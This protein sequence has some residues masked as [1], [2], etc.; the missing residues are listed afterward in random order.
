MFEYKPRH[1]NVD[2]TGS[3]SSTVKRSAT[4]VNVTG[5]G[6]NHYKRKPRVTISMAR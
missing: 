1:T 4:G 5:F 3:D 6:D 2:I